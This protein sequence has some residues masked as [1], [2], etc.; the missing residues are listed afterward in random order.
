VYIKALEIDW[1]TIIETGK[2]YK[3]YKIDKHNRY[4]IFTGEG[5]RVSGPYLK[6][7]FIDVTRRIKLERILK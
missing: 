5:T 1:H 4:W 3:V 7:M 6:H 2:I